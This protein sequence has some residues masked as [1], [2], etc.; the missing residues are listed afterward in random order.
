MVK[1][2]AYFGNVS[3]V[4]M[5]VFVALVLDPRGKMIILKRGLDSTFEARV[6]KDLYDRTKGLLQD[7]YEC[8]RSIE[9]QPSQIPSS[10]QASHQVIGRTSKVVGNKKL[11]DVLGD[12][13]EFD[14]PIE[15]SELDKYLAD[16]RE[17]P[18]DDFDLLHYWKVM[19][20]DFQHLHR[21]LVIYLPSQTS[22]SCL[23]P[24][25]ILVVVSSQIVIVLCYLGLLKH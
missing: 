23:S 17:I 25:S 24:L 21:L 1:Y 18:S 5:L 12:E 13:N 11:W 4:N 8:Y 20:G 16:D 3:K 15:R 7:L 19:K 6:A 22:T 14:V 2:Y 9:A 10:S